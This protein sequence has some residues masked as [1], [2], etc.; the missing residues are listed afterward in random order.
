MFAVTNID[1]LLVLAVFFGQAGGSRAAA[2][3][4]LLGQYLGFAGILI[5][6][7]IGALGAGLLPESVISYLGL[8]PLLLGLRAAWKVVREGRTPIKTRTLRSQHLDHSR[9]QDRASFRSRLSRWR[10]EETTSGSTCR[11]SPSSAPLEWSHTSRYSSSA[12]PCGAPPVGFSPRARL[13]LRPWPVGVTSSCRSCSS[14]SASS[15]LSKAEPSDSERPTASELSPCTPKISG[16]DPS[17]PTVW[18]PYAPHPLP[19]LFDPP[20]ERSSS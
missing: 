2:V 7:V 8:L 1:D 18:T 4:V 3:R 13:W 12:W 14:V 17:L 16:F 10:T 20:V 9:T 5:V 6:S 15:S 11:C 19:A